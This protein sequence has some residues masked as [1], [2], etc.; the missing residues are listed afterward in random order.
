MQKSISKLKGKRL[1]RCSALL[2]IRSVVNTIAGYQQAVINFVDAAS[3]LEDIPTDF[4][5]KSPMQLKAR[6]VMSLY[7]KM[8][9]AAPS[10]DN[11]NRRVAR[12]LAQAA[13]L[14]HHQSGRNQPSISHSRP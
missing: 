5:R 9:S 11:N 2:S 10:P 1:L 14:R 6:E 8:H 7:A 13:K 4:G 3:T 12:G